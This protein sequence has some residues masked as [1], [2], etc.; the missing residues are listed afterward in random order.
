MTLPMHCSWATYVIVSEILR[1]AFSAAL[2]FDEDNGGASTSLSLS[3]TCVGTFFAII[4][5]VSL[6]ARTPADDL[7]SSFVPCLESTLESMLPMGLWFQ[8]ANAD[9][10]LYRGGVD[11]YNPEVQHDE[12]CVRKFEIIVGMK[13]KFVFPKNR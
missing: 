11:Q 6:L 7:W 4:R 5:I 10:R 13:L 9:H 12:C 3:D 1:V 8:M 2:F